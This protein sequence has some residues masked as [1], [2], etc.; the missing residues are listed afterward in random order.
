MKTNKILFLDTETTGFPLTQGFSRFYDYKDVSKYDTCRIVSYAFFLSAGDQ[1]N[2][3][4]K[5]CN[6]A[7]PDDFVIPN[8]DF[9]GITQQMALHT[10]VK[11]KDIIDVLETLF[12]Q[13]DEICGHNI[14]FDVYVLSSELHRRGYKD[15]ALKFFQKKRICTM[16]MGTPITCLPGRWG[17]FK[18][19]KLSE[20]YRHFFKEEMENAHNAEADILNTM[21]CYYKLIE[22]KKKYD[23]K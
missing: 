11:W 17:N 18:Y 10:G 8:S 14:D 23:D 12:G 1:E 9:H 15:L 6:L 22:L 16:K 13:S 4:S 20:L 5:C 3:V 19:P 21:K 7:Y 2:I